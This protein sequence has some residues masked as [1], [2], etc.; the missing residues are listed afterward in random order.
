LISFLK[1]FLKLFVNMRLGDKLCRSTNFIT[2][3]PMDQKL[4]GNEHFRRSLGKVGKYWN[5]P[6]RVDYMCPKM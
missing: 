2:F 1:D 3:G 4:W 5:Q 6:T